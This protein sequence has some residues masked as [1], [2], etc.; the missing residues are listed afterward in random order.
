MIQLSQQLHLIHLLQNISTPTLITI[1]HALSFLCS[2]NFFLVFLPLIIW[3]IDRKLGVKLIFFLL[4]GIILNF[5]IK[6]IFQLPRP[7]DLVHH[8]KLEKAIIGI[9]GFPSGHAQ[10]SVM[11]W[12]AL[13]AAIN[14]KWAW[15]VTFILAFGVGMSRL[16]LGSHFPIDVIGGWII[17]IILLGTYL[18]F[19]DKIYRYVAKTNIYILTTLGLVLPLIAAYVH[20]T[21][22]AVLIFGSLSG[23]CLG[24]IL[25]SAFNIKTQQLSQLYKTIKYLV[26]ISILLV[27]YLGLKKISPSQTNEYY[28]AGRYLHYFIVFIWT[29]VGLDYLFNF[30]KR[31]RL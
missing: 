11:M 6:D 19:G 22:T 26:G 30:L 16:A 14:K 8:V 31:Q 12:G 20:F 4:L 1:F 9:Y 25:Y 17:G 29:A 23:M 10:T 3:S 24:C 15:V 7:F 27:L 2:E 21:K 18:K 28:L 13:A 5:F